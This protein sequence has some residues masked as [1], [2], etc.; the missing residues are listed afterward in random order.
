MR[1]GGAMNVYVV[2]GEK[3]NHIRDNQSWV[4]DAYAG[5]SDAEARIKELESGAKGSYERYHF[6]VEEYDVIESTE[7]EET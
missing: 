2:R 4:V 3:G 1:G 5:E 6:W 7:K